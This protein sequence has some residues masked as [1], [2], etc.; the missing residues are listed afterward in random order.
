MV[1]HVILWKLKDELTHGE[2]EAV[3]ED[4]RAGLEGLKGRIPGLLKIKIGRAH[5]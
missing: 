1:R 2:K 3:K 5:V 4:I